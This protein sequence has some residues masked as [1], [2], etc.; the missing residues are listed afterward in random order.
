MRQLGTPISQVDFLSASIDQLVVIE[1]DNWDHEPTN[2][3]LAF[4]YQPLITEGDLALVSDKITVPVK[5]GNAS[6]SKMARG[7]ATIQNSLTVVASIADGSPLLLSM[8]T[9]T[10][11]PQ[12]TVL[13]GTGQ[14]YPATETV[15][16]E[17]ADLSSTAQQT[18]AD[19]LSNTTNPVR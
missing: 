14:A 1:Q 17:T 6:E 4:R 9:Q 11:E 5:K 12:W 13:G 16:A 3:D 2:I 19:D 7:P 10:L 8:Y 15:V 18:I